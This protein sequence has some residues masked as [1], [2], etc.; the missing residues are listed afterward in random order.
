MRVPGAGRR[1]T[2]SPRSTCL[3]LG[4]AAQRVSGSYALALTRG[5]PA[6][7]L[8]AARPATARPGGSRSVAQAR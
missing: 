6:A 1:E 4:L 8:A 3:A 7:V 5:P 2:R